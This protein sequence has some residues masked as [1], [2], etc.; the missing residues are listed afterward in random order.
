MKTRY[1]VLLGVILALALALPPLAGAAL[2]KAT[3]TLV[4]PGKSLGGVPLGATSGSVQKAWGKTKECEYQCIYEGATNGGG[5]AATASVLLEQPA[6]GTG[7]FKVWRV[8]VSVGLRKVGEDLKPDFNTALS[9]FQ[10]SKGIGIGSSIAEVQRAYPAAKK[11]SAAGLTSFTLK[12]KGE[13][14]TIFTASEATKVTSV[15]VSSHRAG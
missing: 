12:G 2:P 9:E 8:F 5:T 14:E 6:S 4:V 10:T 1:P 15:T 7:P 11:L 3:T 13:I